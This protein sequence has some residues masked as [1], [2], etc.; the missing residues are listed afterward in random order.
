[1]EN[2]FATLFEDV[3]DERYS[4]LLLSL[5]DP[6]RLEQSK[7]IDHKSKIIKKLALEKLHRQSIMKEY[8][9]VQTL[10]Q[11]FLFIK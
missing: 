3:R 6:E 11:Y 2:Y 9:A 10:K 5:T 1:M 4:I 8:I 7:F